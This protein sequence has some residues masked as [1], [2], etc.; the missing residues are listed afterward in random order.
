[1]SDVSAP[2]S[3]PVSTPSTSSTPSS[4]PSGSSSSAPDTSSQ[5]TTTTSVPRSSDHSSGSAN[6]EVGTAE[7]KVNEAATQQKVEQEIRKLKGKVNGKEVE[8]TEQ[9]AIRRAQLADSADAKFREAADMRRQVEQAIQMM[10]TDPAAV[11]TELGIDIRKFAEEHLGR[12]LQRELM[13]PEERELNDLREWKQQFEDQNQAQE[14]ERMSTAQKAE[15]QRQQ[16]AIAQ[17]YDNKISEVLA[18]SNLP[19]TAKTVKAVAQLMYSALD[20]GYDL[21]IATAVDMVKNDYT[22]SIQ[23]LVGGMDGEHLINMLG[24]DLVRKIRKHD[25]AGIR[26]KLEGQS[27]ASIAE[28]ARGVAQPRREKDTEQLRPDE[29]KRRILAKAGL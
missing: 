17:N 9:E 16:N 27:P 29:W 12:E 24:P 22:G 2:V 4:A 14:Q 26:K 28:Q 19:K 10:Q 15:M 21:D 20:K 6:Q 7:A 5:T 1:M 23:D 3:A 8:W 18:Q 11:L 13:S 25:L